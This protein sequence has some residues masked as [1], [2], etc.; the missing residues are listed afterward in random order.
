MVLVVELRIHCS[1][2]VEGGYKTIVDMVSLTSFFLRWNNESYWRLSLREGVKTIKISTSACSKK[3][4][5]IGE[6][7]RD[8]SLELGH[9]P[10]ATGL[11]HL[12]YVSP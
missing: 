10:P 2:V 3:S 9:N 12:L 6:S 7:L 8:A 5:N 11:K 4:T 1:R